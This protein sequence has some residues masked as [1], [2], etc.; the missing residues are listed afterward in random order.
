MELFTGW[1]L[2]KLIVLCVIAFI[3]GVMGYYHPDD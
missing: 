3:L 2:F 1:M